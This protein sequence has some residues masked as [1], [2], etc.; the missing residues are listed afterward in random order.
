MH[1]CTTGPTD[2]AEKDIKGTIFVLLFA[3][4]PFGLTLALFTRLF[5]LARWHA[6]KISAQEQATGKKSDRKAFATF[7][8]MTMCLV[9]GWSPLIG[10][11]VYENMT[12]KAPSSW[13][14][15]VA[16]LMAFSNTVV[17]VVVYY[18]RNAA[19][20]QT[21]KRVLLSRCSSVHGRLEMPV[22][23]LTSS[24]T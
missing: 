12:R 13:L 9:V 14:V 1:A 15:C 8:I 7:F 2:P 18:L 22:I 16:Q 23:S 6:S 4:V 5:L 20:K 19:F 11:F 10:V 21:A 17:N 24:T 3:I